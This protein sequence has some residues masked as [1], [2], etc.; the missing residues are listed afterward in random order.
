MTAARDFG[1]LRY[2]GPTVV[3]LL[4]ALLASGTGSAQE[5]GG[6]YTNPVSKALADTIADPSTIKADD[7]YW[8]PHG[9]GDS[10]RGREGSMRFNPMV[11][12]LQI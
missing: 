12:A 7:I 11:P 2:L 6:T 8:C 4:R 1:L 10:P 5:A 3:L 9:T